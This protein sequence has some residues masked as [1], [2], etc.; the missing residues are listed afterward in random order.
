LP[1]SAEPAQPSIVVSEAPRAEEPSVEAPKAETPK[2]EAPRVEERR[3][4]E[5]TVDTR[6]LLGGAGLVMI[7]TDPT[8]AH[9]A[10]A[11]PEQAPPVGRPR[12]QRTQAQTDGEL[13]QIETRK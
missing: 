7:E 12:R 5:P 9:A 10:P 1:I 4:E 8:K 11:E 13:V 2:P 3:V 6:L